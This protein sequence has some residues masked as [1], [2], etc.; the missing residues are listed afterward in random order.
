LEFI[1]SGLNIYKHDENKT[2]SIVTYASS[3]KISVNPIKFRHSK[4]QYALDRTNNAI[5]KGIGSVKFCNDIIGETLYA[6]RGEP[7]ETFTDLLLAIAQQTINSRQLDIL[8]R[9]DFFSEFGNGKELLRI[10]EAFDLLKAGAAKQIAKD[11]VSGIQETIIARYSKETAKTYIFTDA[12]SCLK[13]ME[14]HIKS[15]KLDDFLLKEKAAAQLE[16]LGYVDIKTSLP[17][18]INKLFVLG[19]EP[20]KTKDKTSTWAYRISTC[21]VGRGKK[22]EVSILA[23]HYKTKIEKHDTIYVARDDISL[24]EKDGYK[25]NWVSKYKIC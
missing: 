11:K 19:V 9:L 7:Y 4:A 18:D 20:I 21:S 16:Y 24:V 23:R 5:Y 10:V 2:A 6:L 1:T 13:E 12:I 8:I 22:S 14:Q 15:Q 17:E 25:N 3:R